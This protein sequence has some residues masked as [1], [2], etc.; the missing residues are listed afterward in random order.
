[1]K[2]INFGKERSEVIETVLGNY[3]KNFD[4]DVNVYLISIEDKEKIKT[5][6]EKEWYG[7]DCFQKLLKQIAFI[8]SEIKASRIKKVYFIENIRREGIF[9]YLYVK[10]KNIIEICKE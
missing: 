2:K 7:L 9:K 6:M 3:Y 1:M 4:R 5:M 10:D 8:F